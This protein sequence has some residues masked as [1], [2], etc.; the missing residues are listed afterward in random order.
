MTENVAAF[1]GRLIAV[2]QVQVGTAD[3]AGRD[4]DHRISRVL[5]PWI[6]NRIDANVAFSVPA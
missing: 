2:K 5:N 3:R 4:L 1:H 6:G